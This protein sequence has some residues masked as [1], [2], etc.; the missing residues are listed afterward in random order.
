MAKRAHHIKQT[1]IFGFLAL[2]IIIYLFYEL[3]KKQKTVQQA[4]SEND[5]L[6]NTI[7]NLTDEQTRW[8]NLYFNQLSW[9]QQ[10]QLIPNPDEAVKAIITK[11]Q[12]IK[13]G[14]FSKNPD[15]CHE[16]EDAIHALKGGRLNMSL[17][18][19]AKIIENL[20]KKNL[21]NSL[22]FTGQIKKNPTFCELIKFAKQK[23]IFAE[24]EIIFLNGIREI[25]N[26]YAHEIAPE[27]DKNHLL[28]CHLW[29]IDMITTIEFSS[30]NSSITVHSS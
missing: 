19:L 14:I 1:Q 26:G 16:V 21:V 29:S 18:S 22:Q 20:L 2:L 10:Y 30:W 28:S 24:D 23:N 11:L 13:S 27:N 6:K 12:N 4:Q 5:N 9:Q 8:M 3:T 17:F 25:R 15:F 7:R